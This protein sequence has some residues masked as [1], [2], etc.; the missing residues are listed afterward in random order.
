MAPDAE[1]SLL[2]CLLLNSEHLTKASSRLNGEH[3]A[4]SSNRLLWEKL[5]QCKDKHGL[6]DLVT[7]KEELTASE[8]KRVG[9][10]QYLTSLVERLPEKAD[11]SVYAQIL[12][13]SRARR[14]LHKLG[15]SIQLGAKEKSVTEVEELIRGYRGLPSQSLSGLR[16]A[17][18][19][20]L[21]TLQTL[22][23]GDLSSGFGIRGLDESC[24]GV[25]PRMLCTFGSKTS[26]GKTAFAC[27]V[28]VHNLECSEKSRVLYNVFENFEQ[29]PLRIASVLSG[30]A[31]STFV[32]SSAS[33]AARESI[34]GLHGRY[35]DRLNITNGISIAEL[36]ALCEE[37]KP[38]L[39]VID[40]LQKY[41]NKFCRK[42]DNLRV[43]TGQV[44]SDLQ[45]L[46]IR[47]GCGVLLLSQF[48]RRAEEFRSRPPVVE[49]L[50]ESGD[51]ENFSDIILLGHWPWRDNLSEKEDPNRYNILVRK[52][53]LG[54]CVDVA[55]RINLNTLKIGD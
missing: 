8:L 31:L 49:D 18:D 55:T 13:E 19:S 38:T 16:E 17:V 15:E 12:M 5:T 24:V 42:T 10:V 53:K 2:G 28:A 43:S 40:Y 29:I 11:W 50:K 27:G 36:D 34:R 52:N 26:H 44:V 35:G 9:G 33:E 54:P 4:I 48:S 32:S 14:E 7:L 51:I 46:G 23:S 45:D 3:F 39:L 20:C 21:S 22:D 41:V 47:R 25:N 30:T 6:C 37:T 1:G